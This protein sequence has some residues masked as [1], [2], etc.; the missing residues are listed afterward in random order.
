MKASVFDIRCDIRL[1]IVGA[2]LLACVACDGATTQ[3]PE[4]DID[5]VQAAAGPGVDFVGTRSQGACAWLGIPYTAPMT[6]ERRFLPTEPMQSAGTIQAANFGNDCMQG[7]GPMSEYARSEDCLTLNIWAPSTSGDGQLRQGLPVMVWIHGGGFT[8]GSGNWSL[9][10]GATL[11]RE[12]VVL[13]TINYRLGPL[14]FTAP[15]GVTHADGYEL[16][17]NLGV[18]DAIAALQWVQ[19]HIHIFGGDPGNV[20]IFGESAGSWMV[21]TLLGAGVGEAGLVHRAAMQSGGCYIADRDTSAAFGHSWMNKTP[22]PRFGPA[23]Y[24]CLQAQTDLDFET[25]YTMGMRSGAAPV[26]DGSLLTDQPIAR[27]RQGVAAGVPLIVGFTRDEFEVVAIGDFEIQSFRY[28][29]WPTF[30]KEV[31]AVLGATDTA[32]AREV[33]PEAEFESPFDVGQAM[34]V[35]QVFGCASHDAALAQHGQATASYVYRFGL[36]AQTFIIEPYAGAFHGT[37]IPFVFGNLDLLL[38]TVPADNGLE[39]AMAFSSRVRRYWTRFAQTGDPNGGDDPIWPL[40]G[41]DQATLELRP[42]T[43]TNPGLLSQ[44]CAFWNARLPTTLNERID[45]IVD[46]VPFDTDAF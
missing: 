14:G 42:E 18:H 6:P 5:C 31:E 45:Y 1:G 32:L 30:W 25:K 39:R 13:A 3:K 33:Y 2:A 28:K 41:Q 17:G 24:D 37:E 9:Y 22:C 21:C 46:H 10:N 4:L 8:E 7:S 29:P 43:T 26:V 36:D 19:E 34:I 16:S 23:A 15:K 35:D 20:M 38:A 27:L 11:A 12:G 40:Y 44:R